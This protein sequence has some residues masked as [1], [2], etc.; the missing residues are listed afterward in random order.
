MSVNGKTGTKN[1]EFKKGWPVV[2]CATLGLVVTNSHIYSLGIFIEPLEQ[3]FGWS[4]AQITSATLVSA[5]VGVFGYPMVGI[6][7]D[8]F[9][10]R[11]IALAGMLIFCP[12]LACLGLVGPAIWSWWIGYVIVNIGHIMAGVSVWTSGVASRF[13]RQRGLALGIC[14]TGAGIAT[15]I[16]P[17]LAN[18]LI[19]EV[20]WSRAYFALGFIGAVVILPV[21]FL[22]F[23]DQRSLEEKASKGQ[24][25]PKAWS[26]EGVSVGEG[27]RTTVFW[28]LAA[29]AFLLTSALLGFIVHFVPML[30]EQGHSR[31]VAAAVAGLIGIFSITGRLISGFTIDRVHARYVGGFFSIL[32]AVACIL[33]LVG[34]NSIFTWQVAAIAIGLALGAEADVLSYCTTRFFGFRSYGVLFGI[35]AAVLTIGAGVGPLIGGFIYDSIGSYRPLVMVVAAASIL[36]SLFFLTLGPYPA[37]LSSKAIED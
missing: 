9:G 15:A 34:V 21:S 23:R 28:R 8:R 12:A 19:N 36:S 24:K 7:L 10:A 30:T 25:K 18:G 2:L 3:A 20:G 31:T 37:A 33:L 32:P 5:I 27:L 17:S 11:R 16:L 35:F 14:L 22:F 13:D 26:P 29:A 6:A 4:R 1:N